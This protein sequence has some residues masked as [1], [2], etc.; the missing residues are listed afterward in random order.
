MLGNKEHTEVREAHNQSLS[1]TG[2]VFV[3]DLFVRWCMLFEFA[4]AAAFG[5]IC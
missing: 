3:C 1:K 5:V 2:C 4:A